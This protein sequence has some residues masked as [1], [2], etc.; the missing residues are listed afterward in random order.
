MDSLLSTH[1]KDLKSFVFQLAKG[2]Y[3]E[4]PFSCELVNRARHFWIGLL[5]S[6]SDSYDCLSKLPEFEPFLLPALSCMRKR[7]GGPDHNMFM[8][9]GAKRSFSTGVPVG[10]N[11]L[12]RTPAVFERKKK[13]RK[14]DSTPDSWICDNYLSASGLESVL[15]K[16]FHDEALLGMMYMF[17]L[18]EAQA[19]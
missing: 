14:L 6:D 13:W 8:F 2:K 4:S 12:P 1:I 3:H 16:Q 15:E 17:P 5:V 18:S 9:H 10:M 11:G 7:L 19:L